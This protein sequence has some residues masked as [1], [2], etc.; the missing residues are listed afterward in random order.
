MTNKIIYLDNN[1]TTC[2]D[3][4]VLEE[5]LPYLKEEYANPSSIYE[6]AKRSNHAVRDARG[7]IKDFFNAK[8]EKE[9]IVRV[10]T[11][12]LSRYQRESLR[13][14]SII[15]ITFEGRVMHFFDKDSEENL[16]NE[17][18]NKNSLRDQ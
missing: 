1:A 6:F 16:L 17:P 3:E 9:I 12:N 15:N 14:G 11:I 2:V 18:Q 7:V 13:Y 4:R 5:M 10:P 8:D